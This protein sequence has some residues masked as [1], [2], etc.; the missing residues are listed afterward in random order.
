MSYFQRVLNMIRKTR[1]K[2]NVSFLRAIWIRLDIRYCKRFKKMVQNEYDLY[3]FHRLNALGRRDYVF[4]RDLLTDSRGC[5]PKEMW[6]ILDNK[7]KFNETFESFLGRAYLA[8]DATT[9]FEVFLSFVNTY[10]M[11]FIKPLSAFGGRGIRRVN[12]ATEDAARELFAEISAQPCLIEETLDQAEEL[13]RLNP[14]SVNTLRVVTMVDRDGAIHSPFAN[15]RI[16]RSD[17]VV[18]NFSSGGITASVDIETGIVVSQGWDKAGNKYTLHPDSRKQII[19]FQV[20]E[21]E[22]VMTTVKSAA[23]MVPSLRYIGWD[24][25]VRKDRRISLIEGNR[26]AEARMFQVTQNRGLKDVYDQ[27]LN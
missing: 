8:I 20:P 4:G 24:V 22:Q 16:G 18:D 10:P 2:Y 11:I 25:V 6:P 19:G 26:A 27:Y 14:S 7:L 3:Q 13:S 21:W 9:P 5:N 1:R 15:I 17:S 12:V 23:A